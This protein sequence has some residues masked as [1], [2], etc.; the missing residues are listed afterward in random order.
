MS[1]DRDKISH[2]KRDSNQDAAPS[3]FRTKIRYAKHGFGLR[4]LLLKGSE[5]VIG[6]C[7]LLVQEAEGVAETGIGW[8][9][10]HDLWGQGLATEAA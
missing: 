9:V 1:P 6:D 7:G 10:R 5:E 4:A 3:L 2:R 8:H